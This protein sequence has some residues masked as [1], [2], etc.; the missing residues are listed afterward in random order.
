MD[1]EFWRQIEDLYY[2]A[3]RSPCRKE[4]GGVLPTPGLSKKDREAVGIAGAPNRT[5]EPYREVMLSYGYEA[6]DRA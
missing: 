1:P 2:A 4:S 6:H 3:R 5:C